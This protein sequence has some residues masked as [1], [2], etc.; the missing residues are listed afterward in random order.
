MKFAAVLLGLLFAGTAFAQTAEQSATKARISFTVEQP[1]LEPA[2]YSLDIY[3][4]GSGSYRASYTV[5]ATG[6]SA[7]E[8]VERAIRIHDPLLADMFQ[9]AR[10]HHFFAFN[11]E[12]RHPRVT[13]TGKKTLAYTGADGAGSCTFNYSKQQWV[14]QL[15]RNLQA[16]AYTLEEG[17]RLKRDQRYDRLALDSELEALQEAA[18][19]GQALEI[20]NIQPELQ[21]I[22]GDAAVMNRARGR[23]YRLISQTTLADSHPGK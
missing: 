11:C 2:A 13:F 22:V 19:N 8:P 15:T 9:D 12:G 3:E 6:N 10:A 7:P 18:R 4:D 20:D 16:V 23:A 1:R 21:S 17:V 5:S 14:D